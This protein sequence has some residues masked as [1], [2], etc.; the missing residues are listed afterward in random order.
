MADHLNEEPGRNAITK[1]VAMLPGDVAEI[2]VDLAFSAG[3]I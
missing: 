1:M 3:R 2:C